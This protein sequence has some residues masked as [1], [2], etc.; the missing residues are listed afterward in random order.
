MTRLTATSAF[1]SSSLSRRR[2]ARPAALA[3]IVHVTGAMARASRS[4]YLSADA[5]AYDPIPSDRSGCH[6]DRAD[7][8]PL[9]CA[10]LY[11]RAAGGLS[12]LPG[13]RG[14]AAASGR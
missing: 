14:T 10:R 4:V 11:R 9:V 5:A 6:L 2:P 7:C 12:L 3:G 1:I 8:H 13:A